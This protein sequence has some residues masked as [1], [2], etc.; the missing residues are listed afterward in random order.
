MTALPGRTSCPESSMKQSRRLD[1]PLRFLTAVAGLCAAG[2][3]CCYFILAW[4]RMRY[5]YELEWMEGGCVDHVVRLLKGASLYGEPSLEFTPFIYTPFYYYVS[6]VF[7]KVFGIGFFPL[8]LVSFL[9][10]IGC[11]FIIFKFVKRE[12]GS[13]FYGLLSTGLFAAAYRFSGA[14][15]DLARLD[16]L[17]LFLLLGSAYLLFFHKSGIGLF[18]SGVLI[19]LSFLTKQTALF[20]AVVMCLYSMIFLDRWLKIIIPLIFAGLIGLSTLFFNWLSHGWYSYYVFELPR[21]HRIFTL[22]V[23]G[24]WIQDMPFLSLALLASLT[25]LGNRLLCHRNKETVFHLSFFFSMI[26]VS[27]FSRMHYGGY[28][29]VLLLATA[30]LSIYA[31]MGWHH[32]TSFASRARHAS[33]WQ[34]LAVLTCLLQFFL[35]KYDPAAQLPSTRDLLAGNALVELMKGIDG[36]IFMPNHG[37]LPSLAGKKTS[38][39]AMALFD[40]LRSTDR[41]K[42][43]NLVY[44]I[45]HALQNGYYKTIILDGPFYGIQREVDASYTPKARVFQCTDCFWPVTGKRQ[46]L[47]VGCQRN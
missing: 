20:L 12:T 5:P 29:N 13:S 42:R 26:L 43:G 2:Y 11:F 23:A 25:Y 6:A 30:A 21:Q 37:Y 14:W 10:S 4:I 8:R 44:Q 47:L 22:M 39:H 16:S 27:W 45:D 7:S 18:F 34:Y 41:E 36:D 40:V 38:A 9:A 28:D 24:F 32:V 35:L 31:G 1:L 33:L 17:F 46:S 19:S 3:L 15:L